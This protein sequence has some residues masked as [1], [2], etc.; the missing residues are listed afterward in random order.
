MTATL[1]RFPLIAV[2]GGAGWL[3]S[4]L[5]AALTTGLDGLGTLGAGGARVRCLVEPGGRTD[6]LKQA[7]VEI[8]SGDIRDPVAVAGVIHPPGR[9][10]LFRQV[11]VGGAQN[12]LTAAKAVGAARVVMMSSNSPFGANPGPTDVFDEDSP[13]HPY[14]GYGRSKM[15][16]ERLC[17]DAIAAGGGPEIAIARAPWFYGP[18]QPPRQTQFFTMIREGKFPLMGKG[19]NRRSMAYVDNLALGLLLCGAHEAAA[20]RAWWLA[21]SRPYPM[22]E[23]VSSVAEVLRTDFGMQVADRTLRVPGIISDCARL[24]DAALQA[25]GLYH[26]KIHVLSEM[27]LTIA[28]SIERARAELGFEPPYDL[29]EGMRRSVAWCLEQG[30]KI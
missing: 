20:N 4:R 3:G 25:C 7:G 21:D 2:T 19:E 26:Q 11:N 30:L 12:I 9:T 17:F 15:E 16:M 6:A 24:A 29:R 18:G 22:A 8:V 23:V 13:Y 1:E 5:V 27:N 28:C 14:M 10:S